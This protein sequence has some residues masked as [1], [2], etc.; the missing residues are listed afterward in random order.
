[1]SC[2]E[3]YS[4]S[5]CGSFFSTK[6]DFD[7]HH[8]QK[9]HERMT[10]LKPLFAAELEGTGKGLAFFELSDEFAGPEGRRKM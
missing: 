7:L 3:I 6:E 8:D 9:G 5:Q 2:N 1:M 10:K 4:C